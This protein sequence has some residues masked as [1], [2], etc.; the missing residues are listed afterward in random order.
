MECS[1]SSCP[2]WTAGKEECD[3]C[4][5][6]FGEGNTADDEQRISAEETEEDPEDTDETEE[7]DRCGM[8]SNSS[9]FS[10]ADLKY[11]QETGLFL[12]DVCLDDLESSR[13][14][15][16]KRQQKIA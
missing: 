11:D 10:A 4:L 1:Y 6:P 14:Q 2:K 16:R 9:G 13:E 7:R 5:Y 15:E 8:C 12:C 3:D